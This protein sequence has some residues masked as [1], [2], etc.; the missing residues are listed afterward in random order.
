MGLR[1][2]RMLL[3]RRAALLTPYIADPNEYLGIGRE[4]WVMISKEARWKI[5]VITVPELLGD[6][7]G[8]LSV[9]DTL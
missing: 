5:R 1:Q 4:S 9:S 6:G 3:F 8:S 2:P 7:L